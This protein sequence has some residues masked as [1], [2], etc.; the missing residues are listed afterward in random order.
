MSRADSQHD[1]L[2]ELAAQYCDGALSAE[3]T[4]ALEDRL[5][6][7]PHEM[8]S[9]VLYM[10]IHSQLAW[11]LRARSEQRQEGRE[12]REEG[13][14]TGCNEG[15]DSEA[16]SSFTQD[17][18]FNIHHSPSPLPPIIIQTLPSALSP[19]PSFVGSAIFSYLVA[20]VIVG[21]GLL[22][23]AAWKMSTPMQ[24]VYPSPPATQN[25]E[26]T[27]GPKMQFVGRITAMVDC[28]WAESSTEPVRGA[29]VPIGRRYALS[30]GLLEITYDSGAKVLLQAPV[31]YEVES[32]AG[33]YLSIGKLTAR[34]DNHSE[35]SKLK[36]Q[37]PN[38]LFAVRTPTAVVTDLGT[39]FGVEVGK[40]GHTISYVY[41]GL[42]RLQA[43]L[44]DGTAHGEARELAA[45]Q[46]ARVERSVK[47]GK[48]VPVILLD[49]PVKPVA[50][51]R[52][53]PKIT[54]KTLDLVDV[55]A[56]GDGFSGRRGGGIDPTNGKKVTA[57]DTKSTKPRS[58]D[59]QYHRVEGLPL[60]DGVFIPDGSK[61]EV[62]VDSAG[63]RFDGFKGTANKTWQH[64]WAAGTM[65]PDISTRLD[66]IDF[67]KPP[68]G[69]LYL[70]ASNAITF[71]LDVVRRANPDAKLLRFRAAAANLE[72]GQYS[73]VADAW[74]LI[75]GQSRFRRQQINSYDGVFAIVVPI[76]E[77]DR[78]LTLAATDGGNGIISHDWIIFGDPKLE[79]ALSKEK[80]PGG[81]KGP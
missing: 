54:I 73:D 72:P 2:R 59:G 64:I 71:D 52:E 60:V 18:A 16:A 61:P 75:D 27:P 44:P 15:A 29:N 17:A 11:D 33:G 39:E 46:S 37:I 36:S 69:L 65:P 31:A 42:V 8:E 38:P 78:F 80:E 32:P 13:R 5:R 35:I 62:Q 51:L 24:I 79:M 34:L 23:A 10:E 56:G 1:P 58:G 19:L 76:G 40:D 22:V 14:E 28:Q 26:L 21:I 48:A 66:G 25:H 70:H 47:Q 53:I 20:A 49:P 55:V 3:R 57:L 9:F 81:K 45:N 77:H 4:A 63:H 68:H 6:D 12:E 50:F 43:A 74:V 67:V 30:S 41:R 7:D